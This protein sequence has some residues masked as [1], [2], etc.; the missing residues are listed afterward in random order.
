MGQTRVLAL[1]FP[2]LRSRVKSGYVMG[3]T[4]RGLSSYVRL[5]VSNYYSMHISVKH[6]LDSWKGCQLLRQGNWLAE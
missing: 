4:T 6:S 2:L 3:C 1:V 5:H